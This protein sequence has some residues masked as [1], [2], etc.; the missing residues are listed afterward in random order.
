MDKKSIAIIVVVALIMGG[1]GFY[2]GTAYEKKVLPSGGQGRMANGGNFSGKNGGAQQGT[3]TQGQARS[4][5]AGMRNGNGGGFISGQIIAMDDKSITVKDRNG[6]SKIIL[7]SPSS[8]VGKTVA[9]SS[10]D[11]ATG[12]E[13]M[14]NGTTNSD[15]SVT[16]E[17]IQIRP[18]VPMGNGGPATGAGN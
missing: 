9:G 1:A 12:Q 3:D 11:L 16:A 15:G 17:N 10:T 6:S 14:V 8:T 7:Y 13:V 18:N 4:G 2:G 5:A